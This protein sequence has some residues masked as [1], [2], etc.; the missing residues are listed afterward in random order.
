MCRTFGSSLEDIVF[1]KIG[2]CDSIW[3][4]IVFGL[5]WRTKLVLYQIKIKIIWHICG[6]TSEDLKK[7]SSSCFLSTFSVEKINWCKASNF[8][9]LIIMRIIF[10]HGQ[11]ITYIFFVDVWKFFHGRLNKNEVCHISLFAPSTVLIFKRQQITNWWFLFD[12]NW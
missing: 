1:V 3:R 12:T 8:L 5:F 4:N 7:N 9:K 10:T 11:G 2:W 6:F